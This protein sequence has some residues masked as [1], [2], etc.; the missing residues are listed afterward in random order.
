MAKIKLSDVSLT[1]GTQS[2]PLNIPKYSSQIIN[3]ANGYAKA[4]KPA[5]VGMV[6]QEIQAQLHKSVAI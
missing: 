6:S 4:T 3:L 2:G 5:H 1:N